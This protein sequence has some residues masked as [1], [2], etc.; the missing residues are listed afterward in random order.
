MKYRCHFLVAIIGCGGVPA[1]PVLHELRWSNDTIRTTPELLELVRDSS[2]TL[3]VRA[4]SIRANRNATV[5]ADVGDTRIVVLD[6]AQRFTHRFGVKGRGPGE[7][8]GVSHIVLRSRSVLVA[9]AQNGR[10]SEFSLDGKFIRSFTAGFAAGSISANDDYVLTASRSNSHYA[11]L[12]TDNPPVSALVRPSVLP[13]EVS[14]RWSQLPGHDLLVAD[15][16]RVWVFDQGRA[17]LCGYA[18]PH[19]RPRC[20]VLPANIRHR[21][22]SYRSARVRELERAIQMRVEA[23]P[24]AKDL[25]RAGRY[26]ALLL[27]LADMPVVLIDPADATLTPI[28]IVDSPPWARSARSFAWDGSG[29]LLIG[30]EGMG[31]L[32]FRNSQD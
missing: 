18:T 28:V 32:R 2:Q 13:G 12:L 17:L 16:N 26:L 22:E 21:L 23:A 4:A 30:D 15:S 5:I 3:I 7:I 6:S 11:V 31:R 27:P 9:E 29:F 8:L 14:D 24:L 1:Q 20:Q 19:S 25:I 10:V